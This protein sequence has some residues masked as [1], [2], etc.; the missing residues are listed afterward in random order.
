M[1]DQDEQVDIKAERR[2]MFIITA[3][4]VLIILGLMGLGMWNNPNW[5]QLG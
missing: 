2:A 3:V 5:M 1:T 4:G